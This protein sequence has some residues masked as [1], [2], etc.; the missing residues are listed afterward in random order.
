MTT[1]LRREPDCERMCFVWRPNG[2]GNSAANAFYYVISTCCLIL[3]SF[4]LMCAVRCSRPPIH[5]FVGSIL[6]TL[7]Y[8]VP[9]TQRAMCAC[10]CVW[11]SVCSM[12]KY[13]NQWSCR[14]H[15]LSTLCTRFC[16]DHSGS[17]VLSISVC[18]QRLHWTDS[19]SLS[20][21]DFF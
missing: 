9:Y 11:E 10:V 14:F 19:T 21:D 16:F 3:P 7:L 2:E 20:D 8:L 4:V 15:R 5:S 1:R 6:C 12:P 17:Y 18:W 13:I